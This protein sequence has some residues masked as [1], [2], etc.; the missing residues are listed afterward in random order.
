MSAKKPLCVDLDGTLV[1]TDTMWEAFFALI[2]QEPTHIFST[3]WH[4]K[5][6]RGYGKHKIAAKT[7]V[8]PNLLPYNTPLL[9]WIKAEKASGRKIYLVTGSNEK[10][11]H[12]VADYLGIFDGVIASTHK[13]VM[14]GP[15]KADALTTQFG[16][17]G[18]AYAG[19]STA[20]L[21]AW[22]AADEIILVNTSKAVEALAKQ[23]GPVTKTFPG[24]ALTA[25]L[26]LRAIRWHQ[27]I[28]NILLFVP[29]LTA[30]ELM[31]PSAMV[32][33]ALGF[34]S[35][36]AIASA[37]YVMNDLTDTTADRQNAYKK[38][39]PIAAGRLSPQAAMKIGAVLGVTSI[40][41]ALLLPASF[42]LVIALYIL[43]NIAYSLKLKRVIGLDVLIIT[44]LY[45][46]RIFAGSAAT[47]ITTSPWLFI[48]AAGVFLSLALVK[49]VSEI[50]NAEVQGSNKSGRAYT[51]DHLPL[52]TRIGSISMYASL[53]V[54]I[55]YIQNPTV[56]VLYRVPMLLWL[57]VPMFWVWMYRV[58]RITKA[59]QMHED[60]TVFTG[61]DPASIL[62]GVVA[63]TIVFLAS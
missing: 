28:K 22:K 58:W 29:V 33:A 34:I 42:L 41:V 40:G 60:P 55:L 45:V 56:Q 35:F 23:L 32:N 51:S 19:N 21:P 18:F 54:L 26:I 30:H 59:G 27:W 8:E 7:S 10:F 17:K 44:S 9:N 49:R 46:L 13:R 14:S 20:D 36:S 24:E 12:A 2:K 39:R 57:L 4:I 62:A 50:I 38:H 6:G 11:A 63:I 25:R 5:Y 47:G 48:F 43:I 61:K 31:N 3:M 37:V 52:L 53:V 1:L 15:D 16:D